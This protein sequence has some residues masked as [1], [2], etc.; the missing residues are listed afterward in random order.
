MSD[1]IIIIVNIGKTTTTMGNSIVNQV[2]FLR[3][4]AWETLLEGLCYKYIW[5]LQFKMLLALENINNHTLV[6]MG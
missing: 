3:M 2:A 5:W 6:S 4:F 1:N